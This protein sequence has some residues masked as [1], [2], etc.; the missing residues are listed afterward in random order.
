M[1]C[2]WFFSGVS[3]VFGGLKQKN[4][5]WQGFNEP[6]LSEVVYFGFGIEDVCFKDGCD[7]VKSGRSGHFSLIYADLSGKSGQFC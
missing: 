1:V 6:F 2:W 5:F 4:M 7:V 3:R